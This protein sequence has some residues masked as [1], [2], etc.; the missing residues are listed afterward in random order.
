M[1]SREFVGKP[2][3]HLRQDAVLHKPHSA[4]D[5]VFEEGVS[6]EIDEVFDLLE[7]GCR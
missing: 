1:L 4:T 6:Y 2:N 3:I 7:F 5:F